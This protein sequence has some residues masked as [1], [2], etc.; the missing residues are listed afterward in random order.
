[1]SEFL[2][3]ALDACW[4][5][6][7]E[8]HESKETHT[9]THSRTH[10][11]TGLSDTQKNLSMPSTKPRLQQVA[12]AR[13]QLIQE[14]FIHQCNIFTHLLNSNLH[15]ISWWAFLAAKK[16]CTKEGESSLKWRLWSELQLYYSYSKLFVCVWICTLPISW[17]VCMRR[18]CM[19]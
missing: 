16:S 4:D 12:W 5:R 7:L 6:M 2:R 18:E 9:H 19:P 8:E 1:M 11:H 14:H 17:C 15:P 13:L 10:T 3:K